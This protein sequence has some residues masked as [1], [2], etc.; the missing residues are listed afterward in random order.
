MNRDSKFSRPKLD[1]VA[2]E[3]RRW[4]KARRPGFFKSTE[5]KQSDP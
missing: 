3:Y 5:A 1:V 4:C 2:C